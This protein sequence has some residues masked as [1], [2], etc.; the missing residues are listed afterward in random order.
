MDTIGGLWCGDANIAITCNNI[1]GNQLATTCTLGEG[2][3][4]EDPLVCVTSADCHVQPD[5]PCLPENN[6]CGVLMGAHGVGCVA[7]DASDAWRPMATLM[8]APNPPTSKATIR[9]SLA[10]ET[11]F[12][13]LTVYDIAGRLVSRILEGAATPSE[14]S[15][16][17]DGRDTAGAPV[18]AG[19]YIVRLET[20]RTTVARKIVLI[21]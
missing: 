19:A 4:S 20:D 12:A 14:G 6:G 17:W 13:R 10:P 1:W 11:Q 9:Y 21:R 8:I 16:T 18:A 7:T 5:S 15:I 3:I 2:N